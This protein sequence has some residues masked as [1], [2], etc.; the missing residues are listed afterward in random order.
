MM[1]IDEIRSYLSLVRESDVENYEREN[2]LFRVLPKPQTG[3]IDGFVLAFDPEVFEDLLPNAQNREEKTIQQAL[4][5]YS[6]RPDSFASTVYGMT[7]NDIYSTVRQSFA[8]DAEIITFFGGE[9]TPTPEPIPEP[10]PTPTPT[11]APIPIPEPIPT[12]APIPEPAPT[13]APIPEPIPTTTPI[14]TPVPAPTPVQ[15]IDYD[16]IR[17]MM[18]EI[19]DTQ[20]QRQAGTQQEMLEYLREMA[21]KDSSGITESLATSVAD[22]IKTINS[23]GAFINNTDTKNA[24][25][26]QIMRDVLNET[27][28]HLDGHAILCK[29]MATASAVLQEQAEICGRIIDRYSDVEMLTDEGEFLKAMSNLDRIN[30]PSAFMLAFKEALKMLWYSGDRTTVEKILVATGNVLKEG[31]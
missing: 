24:E 1:T 2:P 26:R 22:M 4:K 16:A 19:L 25:D 8:T 29:E 5:L 3:F 21:I 14:P 10:I 11:P 9:P 6:V 15:A 30:S 20:M 7:A 23:I 13:P 27:R 18:Q 17:N 12:P 28:K 31:F